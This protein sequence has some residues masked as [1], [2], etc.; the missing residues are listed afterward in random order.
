MRVD[1]NVLAFCLVLYG[2]FIPCAALAQEAGED[3]YEV[4]VLEEIIVTGSRLIRSRLDSPSPVT[5]YQSQQLLDA[6][7]TTV[8]EFARYLPQNADNF[9]D[10]MTGGSTFKGSAAFN[11][12]GI[13][14]DGTLTLVNGRRVAPFGSSG[15]SEPFVDIN[16]IPVAAIARIE[17]LK[18]GAS[19]IYGSEA[20]AGVVNI[21]THRKMDGI[22]IEGGYMSTTEG[23]GEEWD[24]N[25]SGG[26]NSES[27]SFVGT[28][29]YFNRELIWARDREF[30]SDIDLTDV[31]GRDSRS[32]LSSP[33]T[34]DLLETQARLADPECP[35]RT[36]INSREVFV[37]GQV[38]FCRFNWAYFI[39]TQQPSER[40]GLT[41]SLEHY[42][43]GGVTLFAEALYNRSKTQS[44]MAPTPLFNVF[45]PDY[46]PNNPYGEDLLIRSRGLDFGDRG[47]NTEVK[48]W[49]ALA[50]LRGEISEWDWEAALMAS[51]SE[52]DD[53][54]FNAILYDEYQDA[55]LGFG[56]PNDNQFYNPFGLNP[57]NS[58]EVIDHILISGTGAVSTTEELTADFQATG[59][60]GSLAGGPVGIAIGAQAR[61]QSLTQVADEEELSG[62]IAGGGG[63]APID[64][65]RDIYSVFTEF[66]FPLHDTFELQAA[67]RHDNYSDFGSTTNP[68]IGMGWR[69]IDEIL[70]RATWGTS[71][72]PPTF[73]ELYD[74]G[75]EGFGFVFE[76]V[77]R[78][79]V[80]GDFFDCFGR[81]VESEF[82][83]NP[84]L[85]P[86][87]GETWLLGIAW[88]SSAIRGLSISLDL[89]Q[90]EHTNRVAA[91]NDFFLEE[92][93][94]AL[95]DPFTNPFTVRA[96]QTPEDIALGIPG[97][98]TKRTDTYFN[99][100]TLETNGLDIDF[101][102]VISTS[103]SGTF[104]T[105]FHYTYLNE[106]VW[107][108]NFREA[109]QVDDFAG[110]YGFTGGLP[111]HRANFSLNWTLG[112]HSASMLVPYAGEY[113]SWLTLHEDGRDTGE[114]FVIDDYI[115]LDLQYSY[116]F[117]RLRG[118]QLRLGC[119][120]CTSEDPPVYNQD[121]FTE[122]FHEGRGAMVYVRWQQPF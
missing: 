42:F 103:N 75:S 46:H 60:F 98:I 73:R 109:D 7:I 77:H 37:P 91:S 33:P 113:E 34:I 2:V 5:V 86:D 8:G 26:W 96:P 95:L 13:G 57:Q 82:E 3:D 10:S 40:Y 99:G 68:K 15:D 87:E 122:A 118:G 64:A 41:A 54:R 117:D 36:E 47:F 35:D 88:E 116:T 85:Q 84:D 107:G 27:T 17:V 1:Q 111:K 56:G 48:T 80:T 69:P 25:V 94:L 20:V 51:E 55:L 31:G 89:W 115:Q 93:L 39:T 38:E 119:R 67:V 61:S 9:S 62:I 4:E 50:G 90:I 108:I 76:D 24:V 45:V 92:T 43:S 18:D 81:Q 30:S 112:G 79:P 97:I 44:V 49:R 58:Q 6:G 23:D 66:L 78:C 29:S 104:D 52:S 72:R 22:V 14:L 63:F 71:F 12:R 105:T 100:N 120:N 65:D 32:S 106:W 21:I 110:G 11:L 101:K 53:S 102:Y 16:A 28:L 19:A 74:P 70:V 59:A 121:V 83:G 114:P